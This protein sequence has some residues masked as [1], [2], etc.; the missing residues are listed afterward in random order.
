LS[1]FYGLFGFFSSADVLARG[2]KRRETNNVCV[3]VYYTYS[4]HVYLLFYKRILT[5]FVL[6][7]VGS[8]FQ[9][10]KPMSWFSYFLADLADN[11]R[12][13]FF[14]NLDG[15]VLDTCYG[16]PGSDNRQWGTVRIQILWLGKA[17]WPYVPFISARRCSRDTAAEDASAE[18]KSPGETTIG[19]APIKSEHSECSYRICTSMR[20]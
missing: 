7:R 1:I 11:A 13:T 18:S 20:T 15:R 19:Q 14:G 3:Y 8:E 4:T 12:S 6:Y 2:R 9:I 10:I 5:R 16:C 17:Y